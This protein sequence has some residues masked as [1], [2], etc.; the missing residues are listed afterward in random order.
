LL[1]ETLIKEAKSSCFNF[2]KRSNIPLN[3]KSKFNRLTK[4]RRIV[5]PEC[6][7]DIN[8][9][10]LVHLEE[11]NNHNAI[12]KATKAVDQYYFHTLENP[13]HRSNGFWSDF[14]EHFGVYLRSN[15][16]PYTSSDTASTHNTNHQ[17][18]VNNLL[19]DLKPLSDSINKFFQKHYRNLY[20]K[21]NK[22]KWGPFAPRPFGI[23]PMIAINY[24]IISAYHWDKNDEPNSLCCLVALGDYEGGELCF[25]QLEIIIPLRPNQVVVFSSSFLLHGNLPVIKGIRHS[26]VYFIHKEF[27]SH[28]HK[29]TSIYNKFETEIKRNKKKYVSSKPIQDLYDACNLNQLKTLLTPKNNQLEI[30]SISSNSR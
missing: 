1:T 17:N 28:E 13:S 14:A 12:M 3:F 20:E 2:F 5:K 23:F 24:N 10:T 30:P 4:F 16:L 19:Y 8:G 9:Q 6:I 15:V 18:C 27:F 11:L 25:P 29:L 26:I 21:L 22:L 7:T